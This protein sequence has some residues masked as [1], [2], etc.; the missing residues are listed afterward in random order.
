MEVSVIL[1]SGELACLE[2][3]RAAEAVEVGGLPLH[4]SGGVVVEGGRKIGR[5]RVRGGSGPL[6]VCRGRVTVPSSEVASASATLL[7]GIS[8]M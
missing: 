6:S 1:P 7:A 8:D 3:P 5:L 2:D 4:G